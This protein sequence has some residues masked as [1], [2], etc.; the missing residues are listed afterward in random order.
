MFYTHFQNISCF[1]NCIHLSTTP[2]FFYRNTIHT[3]IST[4]LGQNEIYELELLQLWFLHE[5]SLNA[6]PCYSFCSAPNMRL[7]YHYCLYKRNN[8]QHNLFQELYLSLN[9]FCPVV[10][11][12]QTQQ[13]YLFYQYTIQSHLSN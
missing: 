10:H 2:G 5:P 3:S 6:I 1:Q 11:N 9:Q 7:Y 12:H 4:S 8:L 13:I